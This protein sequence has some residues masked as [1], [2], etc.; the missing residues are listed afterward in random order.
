MC[1]PLWEAIQEGRGASDDR[2]IK[3][4]AQLEADIGHFV[5]GGLI[6]DDRLKQL[7]PY[8]FEH[9]ELISQKPR[10]SLRVFGRFAKA[11][12]FIGT[13]VVERAPLGAKWS[14]NWELEKLRCEDHWKAAGFGA[15]EPF[16]SDS[17]EGYITDN[18]RRKLRVE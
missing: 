7:D 14:I 8:K 10:P 5:E 16:R 11:D 4:W 17:Y 18:A 12:V 3:R 1:K 13:H 15:A 6:T 2:A 9:W